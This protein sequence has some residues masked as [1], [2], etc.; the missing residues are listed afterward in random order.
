MTIHTLALGYLQTN[1]YIVAN[2]SRCILID[3]GDDAQQILAFLNTNGLLPEAIL[4]THGHFD[5]V[6]AA[7][8]LVRQTGCALWMHEGDFSCR[9]EHKNIF[10][11]E[12]SAFPEI[13]FY[14]DGEQLTPAGLCVSVLHTPGHTW[15][16]VC[17]C[18]G[19]ALFSGDTLFQSSIGRTDLPGGDRHWMQS[20]LQRLKELD[21]NY[22]V[23]PGHGPKTTLDREKRV[24][25]YMR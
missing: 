19:D 16:S 20:S 21:K 17:L 24:N 12:G 25:P 4:L 6:G 18:I 23:Y 3:P 22:T 9:P 11:L 5:H 8:A 13:C 2:G 7:E 15:G 14:E 10:P 1:C